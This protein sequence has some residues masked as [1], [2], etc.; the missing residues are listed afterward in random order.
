MKK[1]ILRNGTKK[2]EQEGTYGTEAGVAE[3]VAQRI[4]G[5]RGLG[6]ECGQGGQQRRHDFLVKEEALG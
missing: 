3:G 2:R 4:V 5:G 1:N 6:Q